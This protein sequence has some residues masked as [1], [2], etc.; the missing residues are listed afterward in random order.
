MHHVLCNLLQL[1]H[2]QAINTCNA[3][4]LLINLLLKYEIKNET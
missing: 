1:R 4:A 3:Y 2:K